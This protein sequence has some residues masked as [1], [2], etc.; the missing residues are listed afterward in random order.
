MDQTKEEIQ[1]NFSSMEK[2]V[3]IIYLVNYLF[4]T[5]SWY[6][7]YFTFILFNLMLMIIF[8]FLFCSYI[9]VWN[10]IDARWELQLHRPLH[11]AAYYLNPYYH[12]NPNF[13]VNANIKIGLYQCLKM[14]VSDASE[15]CKIDLQ[16]NSF[17]DAKELFGIEAAKIARDKKN[18][19]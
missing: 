11:A 7:I 19:N 9:P 3:S 10:I 12:Y 17:K 2:K 18:S 15:R 6:I 14:M 5:I 1:V 4:T 8:L 13:K 16:L